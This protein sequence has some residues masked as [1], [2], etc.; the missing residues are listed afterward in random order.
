[1]EIYQDLVACDAKYHRTCYSHYITKA[2]INAV[3]SHDKISAS[4]VDEEMC[5]YKKAFKCVVDYVS[6]NMLS[7]KLDIVTSTELN[8]LYL[9]KRNVSQNG[10]SDKYPFSRLG[11][12]LKSHFKDE[13]EFINRPGLPTLVYSGSLTISEVLLKMEKL[14]SKLTNQ[15]EQGYQDIPE[16]SIDFSQNDPAG[17]LY[18]AV[19]VIR[20]M[21]EKVELAKDCYWTSKDVSIEK[22]SSLIPNL[23]YDSFS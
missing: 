16:I 18:Q 20:N 22:Y 9:E 2:N 11:Q 8:A 3:Q 6:D 23:L 14:N 19:N 4:I 13:I 21:M 10:N 7:K 5:P 15:N 17:I 1:M 12:H